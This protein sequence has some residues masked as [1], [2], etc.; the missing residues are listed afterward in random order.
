MKDFMLV[1]VGTEYTDLGMSPEQMQERMGRWF[2]W[3]KKMTDEGIPHR[4]DALMGHVTRLSGENRTRTDLAS[5]E[6]KELIGGYYIITV[7][8]FERAVEVAKD[9]PD[10][11][12]GSSVEVREVMEYEQ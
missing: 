10:F 2:A 7:E 11:D 4:G 6:V 1:F 3:D 9:F 5:A 8:N 12:L